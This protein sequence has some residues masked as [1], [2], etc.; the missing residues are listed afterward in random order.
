M[1][2]LNAQRRDGNEREI[3]QALRAAGVIVLQ[4]DKS[5]GFDLLC[6]YA[7]QLYILEIKRKGVYTLEPSEMRVKRQLELA[8]VVYHVP[9]DIDEALCVFGLEI[10]C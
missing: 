8:D 2:L 3:I 10:I 9:H 4:M 7:G 1:S 6:A 5:A